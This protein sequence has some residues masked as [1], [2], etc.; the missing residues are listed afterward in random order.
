M[1][2]AKTFENYLSGNNII[3]QFGEL[4]CMYGNILRQSIHTEKLNIKHR[5]I[6][7]TETPH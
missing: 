1:V 6:Y 2:L 7:M 4:Y 5:I 3:E